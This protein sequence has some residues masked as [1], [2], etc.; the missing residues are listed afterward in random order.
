MTANDRF[1]YVL[2]GETIYMYDASTLRFL[3]MKRLPPLKADD[4]E[5]AAP[6][7]RSGESGADEDG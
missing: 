5:D 6:D 1:L 7:E 3:R 4:D 2:R